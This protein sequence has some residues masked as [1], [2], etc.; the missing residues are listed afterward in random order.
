VKPILF[1]DFDGVLNNATWRKKND[2]WNKL[3]RAAVERVNQIVEMS[4]S[5][6]VVSSSW[7]LYEP[8]RDR[9]DRMARVL[10]ENGLR[11][12]VKDV[13]PSQNG[14]DILNS[15]W[16]RYLERGLEIQQ[17]MD[18]NNFDPYRDHF[19]IL[20]D[21]RDMA[22]LITH[23]VQTDDATGLLDEHIDKV[24]ALLKGR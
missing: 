19:A 11:Y 8:E 5:E 12:D 22:H 6:I 24:V 7:R 9:S 21:Y 14:V 23:L 3:D 4:D 18:H 2:A 13:T 20:D 1:L 15:D 17:W 16:H 10:R